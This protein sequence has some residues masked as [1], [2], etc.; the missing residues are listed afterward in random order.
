M[1]SRREILMQMLRSYIITDGQL[2]GSLLI[3][4]TV[5]F[6]S[7]SQHVYSPWVDAGLALCLNRFLGVKV[8]VGAFNK[9]KALTANQTDRDLWLCVPISCLLT[10][11]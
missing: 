2:Q 1:V 4:L 3:K 5:I 9:E 6:G 10:M 8:L 7:A 11:G